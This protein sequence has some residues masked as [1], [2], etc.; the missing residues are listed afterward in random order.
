MSDTFAKSL[1]DLDKLFVTMPWLRL[2]LPDGLFEFFDEF[3]CESRMVWVVDKSPARKPQSLSLTFGDRAD[4]FRSRETKKLHRQV[5][6]GSEI[7]CGQT[8]DGTT[9]KCRMP[10]N[11]SAD[12]IDDSFTLELLFDWK[13]RTSSEQFFGLGHVEILDD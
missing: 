11:A 1:A 4:N 5:V 10:V 13:K 7:V 8:H 12:R 3:Q 9:A 6:T 2:R